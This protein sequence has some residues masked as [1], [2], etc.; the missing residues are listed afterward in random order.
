MTGFSPKKFVVVPNA[1]ECN[2]SFT[3]EFEVI[4]LISGIYLSILS[5]AAA[6]VFQKMELPPL[7][8]LT[9]SIVAKASF[10]ASPCQNETQ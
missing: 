2:K 4:V 10:F 5:S 8:S 9:S 7:N 6:F 1:I 3:G